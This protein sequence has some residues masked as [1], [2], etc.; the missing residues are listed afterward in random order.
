SSSTRWPKSFDKDQGEVR[1]LRLCSRC[2]AASGRTR[3]R[4]VYSSRVIL[5]SYERELQAALDAARRA[6]AL[7]LEHYEHF[8]RVPD[9]RADIS[10][11]A[12]RES[13][14]IILKYLHETF[15]A[16]A[17]CAEETTPSLE[18]VVPTGPRQWVVDPIDGTRGFAKKN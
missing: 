18:G 8:E 13:Q 7:I 11:I 14:E 10:T 6:G 9:A 12:D 1:R 15:P 2:K 5:M 16:D 4:W 3:S 17:L